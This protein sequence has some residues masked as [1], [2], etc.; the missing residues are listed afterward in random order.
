MNRWMD[1]WMDVSKLTI[2]YD[3][4]FKEKDEIGSGCQISLLFHPP[5]SPS[6]VPN[7]L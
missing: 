4:K 2:F 1:G 3:I 5:P 7:F 6:G